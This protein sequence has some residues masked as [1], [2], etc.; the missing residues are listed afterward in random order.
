MEQKEYQLG[1]AQQK[2]MRGPMGGRHGP[3]GMARGGEKPKNLVGTWKKLLAHCKQYQAVM[4]AALV[5]AVLG[6]VLT[7]MGPDRLSAM[8]E[9]ITAGV[10]PD[11]EVLADFAQAVGTQLSENLAE[12]AGKMG[13]NLASPAPRELTYN[14][15]TLSVQDQAEGLTALSAMSGE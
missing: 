2:P 1:Q 5:C 3:G 12:L 15:V 14:G 9:V 13:Q 7:L 4:A 10:T 8:T 11:T 6:T